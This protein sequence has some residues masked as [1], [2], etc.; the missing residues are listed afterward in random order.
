MTEEEMFEELKRFVER[1]YYDELLKVVERGKRALIIDFQDLDRFNPE[2]G[3]KLLDEPEKVLEALKKVLKEIEPNYEVSPRITNLPETR[4]LMVKDIRSKHIG[5]LVYLDGVVRLA[6]DVR[7]V[8]AVI[9]YQCPSCGYMIEVKQTGK[10]IKKPSRCP[11]CGRTGRF[12]VADKRMVDTQRIVLE[13]IP[14]LL[15]GGE[16]PKR[17]SVF[18]QG[19]L[20]DPTI[21]RKTAPG[22]KVRVVGIVREV[23]I[24][25]R[26]GSK[27]T[28]FDLIV[29]ANNVELLE[30]EYEELEIDEEDVKKIRELA[31]IGKKNPKKLIKMFVDSIAPTI[32]GY[33]KIKEAIVYQMFSGVKKKRPDKTVVRG[34]IHI[35]L[36]GDPGVAKSQILKYVAATAPKARYVSGKGATGAGLT[37]T[38]VKDEF[39]R[40]WALE[41]GA[42]VLSSGGICCIDEI[43]KMNKDDRV[44]MHE[45]LEQQTIS[46]SKANIQ[47]TLRAE[48]SVLAAANPK[49]GRFNPYSTIAEQID[50]PPTL[51]NRFDL[52]FTIRDLPARETD[53]KIASYVL[54]T[55]MFPEKRKP[56]IDV[57]LMR[58]YIAYAKKHCKPVLTPQAMKEIKEFYVNL[59][60]KRGI[61]EEGIRPIPISPRQLEA[62]I[63]LSEAS[64]RLLLRDK[65]KVDDAKRAISL[66]RYY[67]RQVGL[68]PETGEI[69]IDRIVTGITATQRS[70]IILIRE[71]MAELEEKFGE[72]IPLREI[73]KEAKERGIDEAKAEEVIDKMK[74]DGEIF[75]PKHGFLRRLS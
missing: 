49:L 57:E 58:K 10:L 69:D 30:K 60:N 75:E 70:R 31:E 74:R 27:S 3:D 66:V 61:E 20:V 23:P 46:I 1:E 22:S 54:E 35:L 34:D 65:V 12:D 45:A 67:L 73:L 50:L 71:I 72:N 44:A 47:A 42:L 4:F 51:I 6:S 5:K 40:G 7:P 28:H 59:R 16:Q 64:A 43:D 68:D 13:E 21:V 8:A 25:L 36:V 17:I 24:Y 9:V 37:A 32:W 53:E 63:R 38:V 62:I 52:I 26:G 39:L 18:L 14:E 2:L 33:E 55:T 41:A 15:E 29:E 19:D 48:T 56:V 11:N